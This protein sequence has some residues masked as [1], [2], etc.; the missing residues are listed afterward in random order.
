MGTLDLMRFEVAW[1]YGPWTVD[2]HRNKQT[3]T[4]YLLRESVC[5]VILRCGPICI[6]LFPVV[7]EREKREGSEGV[8]E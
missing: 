2:E 4:V 7:C 3:D 8:W 1:E 6:N 5:Y